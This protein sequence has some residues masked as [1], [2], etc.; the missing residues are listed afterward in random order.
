MLSFSPRPDKNLPSFDL[1]VI[2]PHTVSATVRPLPVSNIEC[3][4]VP[5]TSHDE[6]LHTPFTQRTAFMGTNIMDRKIRSLNVEERNFPIVH[7]DGL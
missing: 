7:H 2:T 3:Q 5:R 1:D 4:I 6:T